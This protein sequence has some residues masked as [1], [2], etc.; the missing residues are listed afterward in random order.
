MERSHCPPN[1]L[2]RLLHPWMVMPK[3]NSNLYTYAENAPCNLT[4]IAQ[5]QLAITWV[6]ILCNEHSIDAMLLNLVSPRWCM[7]LFHFEYCVQLWALPLEEGFGKWKQVQ[8]REW[9][10]SETEIC[11][12]KWKKLA[13]EKRYWEMTLF[14]DLKSWHVGGPKMFLLFQKDTE[15]WL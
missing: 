7:L 12:P 3:W 9:R 8:Q 5:W 1:T 6:G 2:K 10:L 11:G 15:W 4:A 14:K 13:T